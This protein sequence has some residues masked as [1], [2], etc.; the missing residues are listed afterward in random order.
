MKF[1]IAG[2]NRP[3]S[4]SL[5][6]AKIIQSIHH[7]LGEYYEICDLNKI[8]ISELDG[9]Q[10]AKDQPSHIKDWVT[11]ISQS[12]AL[13]LVVPEYNG[14]MPGA[15]KYFIDHWKYPQSFEYRPVCFVGLGGRFGGLRS[16][17]HLQQVFGYRNSYIFPERVFLIN[18]SQTIKDGVLTDV[19]SLD[20]LKHQAQ[21]FNRFVSAIEREGLD[22]LSMQEKSN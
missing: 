4:K 6:V 11:K 13:I 16:V 3:E 2:T 22:S 12:R 7:E 14:S 8:N 17:E 21:L 18:C 15:L 5:Q 9:S 10:Y 19:A 20:L 1:I